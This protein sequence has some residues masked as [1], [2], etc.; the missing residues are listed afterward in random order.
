MAKV[1]ELKEMIVDLKVELAESL[2][3]YGHCPY[4]TFGNTDNIDV[5]C[6]ATTCTEC[7]EEYFE[8]YREEVRKEVRKL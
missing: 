3:G 5:D 8:N 2:L 4:K 6:N 1:S 7:K